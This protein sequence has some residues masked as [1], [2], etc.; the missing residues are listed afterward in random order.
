MLILTHSLTHSLT[1]C[2]SVSYTLSFSNFT[3]SSNTF[4]DIN[5][6]GATEKIIH[7]H[8]A[9]NNAA[10]KNIRTVQSVSH[11]VEQFNRMDECSSI[12]LVQATAWFGQPTARFEVSTARTDYQP[13]GRANE[14]YGSPAQPHGYRLQPH[15]SMLKPCILLKKSTNNPFTTLKNP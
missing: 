5:F 13:H 12:R 11:T 8:D 6:F 2:N 1:I 14:P 3:F 4:I 10:E 7:A 15:G 9:V